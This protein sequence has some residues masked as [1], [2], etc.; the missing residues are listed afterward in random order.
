MILSFVL[1]K[2]LLPRSLKMVW[3]HS[4]VWVVI[5]AKLFD[6]VGTAWIDLETYDS[7]WW[8]WRTRGAALLIEGLL[9]IPKRR[10]IIRGAKKAEERRIEEE[11][12]K[13]ESWIM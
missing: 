6:T 10:E 11:D 2:I 7:V 8:E 5:W 9:I 1:I 4:L 12:K 3:V 13:A